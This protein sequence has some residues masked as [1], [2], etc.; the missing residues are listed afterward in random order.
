MN[1]IGLAVCASL[2]NFKATKICYLWR[3]RGKK[4]MPYSTHR[5]KPGKHKPTILTLKIFS[6]GTPNNDQLV[7]NVN[8]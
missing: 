8:Y 3:L 1:Q 5:L 4:D 6:L 2:N 7:D